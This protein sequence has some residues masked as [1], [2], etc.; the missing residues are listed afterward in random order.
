MSPTEFIR[1]IEYAENQ[2]KL[3]ARILLSVCGYS[4]QFPVDVAELARLSPPNRCAVNGLLSWM[5]WNSG[6]RL[7]EMKA[8]GVADRIG[9]TLS[10]VEA[11]HLR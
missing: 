6:V 4:G 9:V 5:E 8:R 11:D 3:L 2:K 10:E 7:G 1:F